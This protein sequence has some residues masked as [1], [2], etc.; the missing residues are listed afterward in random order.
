MI[1]SDVE[2]SIAH[3]FS[4]IAS[5]NCESSKV[6]S[7]VRYNFRK[8]GVSSSD[9]SCGNSQSTQSIE[10]THTVG[11]NTRTTREILERLQ[12]LEEEIR[13]MKNN[14]GFREVDDLE[15]SRRIT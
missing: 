14:G 3:Y 15:I 10:Q 12:S 6:P 8:D 11:I 5:L 4:Y 9:P 7:T 1:A 13:G 2:S